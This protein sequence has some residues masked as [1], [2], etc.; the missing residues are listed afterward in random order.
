MTEQK[1]T[2]VDWEDLR[3]FLA[4][5]RHGSLSA[6]ARI[7]AVNHATVA[8]RIHALEKTLGEKLVDRRP[9]GYVLTP[10]GTRTLAAVSDMEAAATTLGR[11]GSQDGP[12]G[13][14]RIN[15]PP[16]LTQGFLL[17]RLASLPALHPGLEIEIATG[18]RAVSL[19]RRESD[20]AVRLAR[21]Q[22]GDLLARP[23]VTMGFGFYGTPAL[24]Q[25]VAKGKTP[26]F[27]GFDESNAYM[28]EAAFLARH[29]PTARLAFRCNSHAAQ[30]TAAAAGAGAALL[31]HYIGRTEPGLKL[32]KIEPVPPTREV[33]L[34]K[35]RQDRKDLPIRTVA[36]FIAKI[37][38][39][40]KALFAGP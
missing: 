19:E 31:P 10:A 13:L 17:S 5:A 27:V 16:A 7:L 8:R 1:R 4:L 34:L 18:M 37:F 36:D 9:D 33:W 39:E 38:A 28:P 29:F 3:V 6:A 35:R 25:A 40:E 30:A 22:D 24:R 12:K 26:A 11:S 14:V 2:G 23:L 32:C 20:I 15:A 21:P